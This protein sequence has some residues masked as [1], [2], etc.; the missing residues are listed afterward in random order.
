MGLLRLKKRR[1]RE[2]LIPVYSKLIREHRKD[3]ARLFSEMYDDS[4]GGNGHKLKYRA[5]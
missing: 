5:F 2:I 1:L 3:G 4:T